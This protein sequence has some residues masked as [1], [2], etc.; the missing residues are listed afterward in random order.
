MTPMAMDGSINGAV[1][2]ARSA[3]DGLAR[4]PE[5]PSASYRIAVRV[6]GM[7]T[8]SLG[9]VELRGSGP[10]ALRLSMTAFPLGFEGTIEDLLIPIDPI[11]P[12]GM[13][14]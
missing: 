8:W 5:M 10:L 3:L 14:R 6:P 4:M 7:I 11:P 1:R 12:A 9:P 13:P 2:L